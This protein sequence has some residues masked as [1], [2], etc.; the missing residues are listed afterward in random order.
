ML[1][2]APSGGVPD[3]MCQRAGLML[4]FAKSSFC[5]VLSVVLAMLTVGCGLQYATAP[6]KKAATD[7]PSAEI[8]KSISTH[9][10]DRRGTGVFVKSDGTMVTANHVIDGCRYL[11]LLNKYGRYPARIISTD[12]HRDIALLAVKYEPETWLPVRVYIPKVGDDVRMIGV[13]RLKS[14]YRRNQWGRR[15]RTAYY[16][17]DVAIIAGHVT[18][19]SSQWETR[20]GRIL[21]DDYELFSYD[22]VVPG[23]SGGAVLDDSGQIIGFVRG[24]GN[25]LDNELIA[26]QVNA[27][28]K[29]LD[30]IV[31]TDSARMT[32]PR[33]RHQL[34][35]AIGAV[36]CF[37][38]R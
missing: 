30:R 14:N 2:V 7:F 24:Y 16:R 15:V 6:N 32:R 22:Q 37:E 28:G 36:L 9:R 4:F 10:P 12:S 13:V 23:F 19:A 1:K 33:T 3:G 20:A 26:I 34:S 29:H 31:A 38:Q 11:F 25:L 8:S 18:R 35:A 21:H 5:V 27:L 17:P